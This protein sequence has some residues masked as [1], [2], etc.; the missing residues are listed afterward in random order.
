[1]APM[2]PLSLYTLPLR[3]S[4][5]QIREIFRILPSPTSTELPYPVLIHCTHGKDRTGLIIVLIL[6]LL[7]VDREVIEKDYFLSDA[8]LEAD[9]QQRRQ[10]MAEKGLGEDFV[11]CKHGFVPAVI[12]KVGEEGGIDDWLR[13]SI[14]MSTEE[15]RKIKECLLR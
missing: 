9:T 13:H 12:D 10:D 5:D 1:M 14:G 2:G 3:A 11:G 8:E 15:L 6:L 4:C 7:G